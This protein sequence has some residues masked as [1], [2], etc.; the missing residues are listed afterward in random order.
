MG[1]DPFGAIMFALTAPAVLAANT[2]MSLGDWGGAA[3][4]SYYATDVATVAG[5]MVK[6][7]KSTDPQFILNLGDSFYWCGIQNTSDFQIAVDFEEPYAA[8]ELQ[9]PWF[10][11]LGNHEYGY[12]PD[13]VVEYASDNPIWVMDDRYF[14]KR[15]EIGAT[16]EYISMVFI[17]TSPCIADYRASSNKYWDPCS[18]TYPTCSITSSDDDFEGPCKFHENII[19]TDCSAQFTWFKKALAAVPSGDW[20]IVV[21][22]HPIDEVDVE[23]FTTALQNAGGAD[24]YFNGHTHTLTQYTIDNAGGYITSGA[25]ACVAV[26]SE[27]V[28]EPSEYLHDDTKQ[29]MHPRSI[30]QLQGKDYAGA[31]HSYQTVWNNKVAGYTS[32]TFSDDLTTLRT[33]FMGVNGAV[34]HSFTVTKRERVVSDDTSADDSAPA[35]E[36]ACC[37]YDDAS[38]ASGDTC[39]TSGCDDPATCSYTESGCLG[40]YGQIHQC[41]WTGNTCLVP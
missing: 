23:D 4:G 11:V 14:T 35:P 37:H 33:D 20:L 38:C 39:C 5:A 30:A 41:S 1:R 18:S 3:L 9:I 26:T 32:H 36:G 15:V 27:E 21:G 7:A 10:G 22:H 40:S 28:E 13:A 24:L 6:Q 17:D 34:L 8:P 31:T 29:P 12:N 25:G 16:G 19:A 2:F